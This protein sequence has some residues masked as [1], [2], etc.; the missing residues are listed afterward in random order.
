M[1]SQLDL[2]LVRTRD[3]PN[4]VS[5]RAAMPSEALR[6]GPLVLERE[7]L[8]VALAQWR[9]DPDARALRGLAA[10]SAERIRRIF[11]R[12]VGDFCRWGDPPRATAM[13]TAAQAFAL[14]R[15]E[16]APWLDVGPEQ[17][18]DVEGRIAEWRADA[19]VLD[20]RFRTGGLPTA[21]L[22]GLDQLTEQ[23]WHRASPAAAV[24]LVTAARLLAVVVLDEGPLR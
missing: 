14:A 1:C 5:V 10:G 24:A 19:D 13:V 4:V 12:L 2:H 18:Q 22:S 9:A 17:P 7:G 6:L 16:D 8:E 3:G 15:L 11:Q 21:V 20:L 23:L